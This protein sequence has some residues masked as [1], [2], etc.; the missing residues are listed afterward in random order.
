[1]RDDVFTLTLQ[2]VLSCIDIE[3]HWFSD[4]ESVGSAGI[5]DLFGDRRHL[6]SG[7]LQKDLVATA[8]GFVSGALLIVTILPIVAIVPIP[9][10]VVASAVITTSISAS[11]TSIVV[12][13]AALLWFCYRYCPEF[14]GGPPPDRVSAFFSL[15]LMSRSDFQPLSTAPATRSSDRMSLW[16]LERNTLLIL[17]ACDGSA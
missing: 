15:R 16:G 4:R 10:P 7:V 12:V 8:I 1:L 13:T 17:L 11:A 9:A 6:Y 5:E 14:C 3:I 2:T